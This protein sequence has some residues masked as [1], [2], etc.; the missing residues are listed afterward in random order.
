VGVRSAVLA[1]VFACALGG[2]TA[3]AANEPVT[4]IGD[5]IS[6]GMQWH[7][8]AT[9]VLQDNLAIDWQVAVC[10]RLVAP[11]CPFEG[12]QAP[13][14]LDVV[15]S[16]GP[17]LA[18]TVV[19]EMGYNELEQ[20]FAQSVETSVDALLAAGAK[21]IIW[22]NLRENRHPY[23][24]MNAMLDA[25][26]KRHPELAVVD[27]NRYSRAHPSWFQSDGEHLVDAGGVGMATQIHAAIE[28]SLAPPVARAANL[29][30]RAGRPFAARLVVQGGSGPYTWRVAA[31][32]LPRGLELMAGGRI[33]GTPTSK[34]SS[35][36]TLWVTDAYG[37]SAV[38]REVVHVVSV[39]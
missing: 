12:G 30:A 15:H 10:R 14:L 23:V 11:S 7:D 6:T 13:T 9:A 35:V 19:V 31:G 38:C 3:S 36:V 25:A 32:K 4:V 22:L 26:G 2:A 8:D 16:L 5:S 34:G 28:D 27:W 1:A 21:R 24:R 33:V 29:R 20:T 18:P 37:M 39:A 17:K